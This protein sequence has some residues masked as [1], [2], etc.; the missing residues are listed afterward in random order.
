MRDFIVLRNK[1]LKSENRWSYGG[2]LCAA[3]ILGN[4]KKLVYM[5]TGRHNHGTNS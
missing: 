2:T 5:R 3:D 4:Q 1:E